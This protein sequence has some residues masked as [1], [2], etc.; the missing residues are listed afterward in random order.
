[1]LTKTDVANLALGK[2]GSTAV[3][4]SLDSDPSNTAKVIKRHFDSALTSILK[5]HPWSVYTKYGALPLTGNNPMPGWQ[6]AYDLPSD[7][8]VVRRL[9]VDSLFMQET[10]YQD[11]LIPFQL[12]YTPNGYQI[13]TNIPNAYAEYTIRIP[14]GSLFVD[15]FGRAFACVLA[16]DIAPSL[17]TNNYSKIKE[18][19][20]AES[21]REISEQIAIDISLRPEPVAADSP[22]IRARTNR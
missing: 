16:Q 15:H 12:I 2:L 14:D 9:S 6:Y 22:F 4:I 21:R 17:V 10:E 19:F 7:C 20:L 3:I 5:K 1:M 18:L 13:Y 8:E 11:Q